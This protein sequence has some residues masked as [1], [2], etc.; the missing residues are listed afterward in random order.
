[1]REQTSA[2]VAYLLRQNGYNAYVVK[3]G[4]RAWRRSGREVE[5]V[6]PE[7]IVKLPRFST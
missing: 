3:G 6:P 4:Y 5:P 7:D 2:R 1:M